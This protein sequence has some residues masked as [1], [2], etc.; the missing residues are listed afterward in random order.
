MEL[1]MLSHP[2]VNPR[3][4][5]ALLTAFGRDGWR[6]VEARPERVWI[7]IRSG[8]VDVH[9]DGLERCPDAVVGRTVA[10]YL[11][12]LRPAFQLWQDAGVVVLNLGSGLRASPLGAIARVLAAAVPDGERIL[13]WEQVYALTQVPEHLIV[14]GSGVTGAEFASA[15]KEDKNAA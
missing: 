10:R 7:R 4:R 6:V 3:A 2:E 1:L 11:D 8:R 13:T 15:Y 5:R 12:V 9:V 14:V